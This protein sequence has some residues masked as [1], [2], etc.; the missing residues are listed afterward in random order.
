MEEVPPKQGGI[1]S[2][3]WAFQHK[4]TVLKKGVPATFCREK[5]L[6][7][8]FIPVR[9]KPAR[10]TD[11]LL[12]G[13]QSDSLL[14]QHPPDLQWRG[15]RVMWVKAGLCGLGAKVGGTSHCP[16]EELALH[17]AYRRALTFLC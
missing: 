14:W 8:L 4:D 16:C 17:V 11:F 2:L 1:P 5:S 3:Y 9:W 13:H 7:T 10:N 12:K 15:K 6:T